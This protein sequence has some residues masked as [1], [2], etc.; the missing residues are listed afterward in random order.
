MSIKIKLQVVE[1]SVARYF[2]LT[3]LAKIFV[4]R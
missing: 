3:I 1:N 4:M 2:N